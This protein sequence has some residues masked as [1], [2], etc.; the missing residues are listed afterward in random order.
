MEGKPA[1]SH[2]YFMGAY[3]D[4]SMNFHHVHCVPP[5]HRRSHTVMLPHTN[6][7]ACIHYSA[8]NLSQLSLEL[9]VYFKTLSPSMSGVAMATR[10]RS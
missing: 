7:M 4:V 2:H 9:N 1:M 5:C 6:G 8:F 3:T 10:M